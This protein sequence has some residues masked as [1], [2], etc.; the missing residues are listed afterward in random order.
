[1]C[2][3]CVHRCCICPEQ[4]IV[5]VQTIRRNVGTLP[6]SLHFH[7]IACTQ[8]ECALVCSQ[9]IAMIAADVMGS[10]M[11]CTATRPVAAPLCES[12]PQPL[13]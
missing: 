8:T 7:I 2:L 3:G 1:M 10:A 13:P 4:S 9:V 6:P 5:L 12:Q 11:G